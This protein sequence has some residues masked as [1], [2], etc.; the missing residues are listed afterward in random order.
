MPRSTSTIRTPTRWANLG[1]AY[2]RFGN[3]AK[4]IESY[5]RALIVDPHNQLAREGRARV[6]HG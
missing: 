1:L 6:G 3:R 4:A 5:Q 2:E